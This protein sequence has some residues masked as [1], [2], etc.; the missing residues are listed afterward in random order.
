MSVGQKCVSLLNR[1]S[2]WNVYF[3][4]V[5]IS[6]GCFS[7][8]RRIWSGEF[9]VKVIKSDRQIPLQRV[10]ILFKLKTFYFL[11]FFIGMGF[12]VN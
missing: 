10:S 4:E 7:V 11:E 6:E 1:D 5:A 8:A 2:I 12:V 9:T 3:K